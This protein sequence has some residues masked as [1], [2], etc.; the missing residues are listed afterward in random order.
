MKK[1]AAYCRFSTDK[2]DKTSIDGQLRNI[3]KLGKREGFDIVATFKDEAISGASKCRPGFDDMMRQLDRFDAILID[4]TARITRGPGELPRLVALLP[5][6]G[7]A[8]TER[9]PPRET[10]K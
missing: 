4:D 3:R 10:G 1:A 9:R 7:I 5:T 6:K 8:G 2:Q